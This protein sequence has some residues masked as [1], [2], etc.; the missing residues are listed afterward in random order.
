MNIYN[1]ALL[2]LFVMVFVLF[3]ATLYSYNYASSQVL[4]VQE[5]NVFLAVNKSEVGFNL[6]TDALYF[7]TIPIGGVSKRGLSYSSDETGYLYIVVSDSLKDL[8]YL[9]E[10]FSSSFENN[11]T[12]NL[13]ATSE[14]EGS[15]SGILRVYLLKNEPGTLTKFFLGLNELNMK[16]FV[17]G[18]QRP[19]GVN[20]SVGNDSNI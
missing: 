3:L 13:L 9:E 8:I 6:D 4:D 14:E 5:V 16:D 20:I 2:T 19:S 15:Y 7:G 1:K 11:K 17:E 12:V 10:G 18:T